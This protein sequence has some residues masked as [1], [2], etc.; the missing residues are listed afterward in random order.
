MYDSEGISS[1][2]LA[3][4]QMG[5]YLHGPGSQ[6]FGLEDEND[7]INRLDEAREYYEDCRDRM[8]KQASNGGFYP[9]SYESDMD[10]IGFGTGLMRVEEN[11]LMPGMEDSKKFGFRGV[12]FTAFKAGRF[13]IFENGAGQVDESYVELRKTAKAAVDLWGEDN[14]P[15]IIKDAYHNG[16]ADEFK[17]IQGI[18]PRKDGEKAYGNKAMPFASC[19]VHHDTKKVVAESGYEEFPDCVPRWTRCAGEPYGRGLGEIALNDLIVLNAAKKSDLEAMALSTRPPL[20]QR[21]D[22]VV[23]SRK[24]QPWGVTV[25]RVNPGESVTNAIA[26]INTMGDYKFTQIKEEELRRS[27]RRIFN[28]DHFEQ[29]M[30][31][32]GQQEYRVYVFQQKMNIVQRMLGPTY[33]RWESEFGIPWVARVFNMMYRAK[34]FVSPPDVIME[35]GGQPKVRFES[36]L[37]RAQRL[38]EIDA[39]NQA[40]SDLTPI[41]QMQL[42][43]WKMTGRQPANWVLDAYDF[44]K[45]AEKINQNRGVAATVTRSER[46]ILAI[47]QSRAE[48]EQA[49]MQQ[50]QMAQVAESAGKAAPMAKVLAEQAA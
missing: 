14:L 24:F 17:F 21:H 43:E 4:R 8:L 37:A 1:A 13:V 20:A 10:W 9:E 30:A 5:S 28:S 38:E 47:R 49:A 31:L 26:P 27:I 12:R 18:Y 45:Y 36:P 50:Q 46:Q 2:D 15:D 39:M 33:G 11:P 35:M 25:V 34:A 16:L 40:M 22:A 7:E 29:L 6:W 19:Y 44:D 3:V 32:E 41:V 42:N 23:G 48:Q